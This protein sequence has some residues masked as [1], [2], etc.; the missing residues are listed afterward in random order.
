MLTLHTNWDG[1]LNCGGFL[2]VFVTARDD[3]VVV[4]TAEENHHRTEV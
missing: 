3:G 2:V 1:R 4:K